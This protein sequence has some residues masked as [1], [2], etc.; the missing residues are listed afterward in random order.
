MSNIVDFK[1][2]KNS[3]IPLGSVIAMIAPRGSGKSVAVKSICYSLRHVPRFI[4]VS[5]TERSSPFFSNFIAPSG[6][7]YEWRKEILT[8][9][10]DKQ[11]KIIQKY[12]KENPK[13]HAVLILD[14]CL[15]DKKIWK[16][17]CITELVLNG[18]HKNITF[19]FTLQ[20]SIGISP[21]LRGNIDFVFIYALESIKEKRQIHE[22]YA[23][24]F[25]KFNEFKHVFDQITENYQCMVINR[26]IKINRINAKIFWFK[27]NMKELPDKFRAG[28]ALFWVPIK[29][30]AEEY[31]GDGKIIPRLIN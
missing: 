22:Y 16:E 24:I 19:I 4:V 13:T 12:G 1:K 30:V 18:R 14:D 2:H 29:R 15:A 6:I 17:D 26:K 3:D 23:G 8:D 10:F 20:Y 28:H 27:A 7:Y 21:A 31:K 5:M 11:D 25:D 9:L